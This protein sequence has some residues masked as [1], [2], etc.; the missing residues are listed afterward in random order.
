MAIVRQPSREKIKLLGELAAESTLRDEQILS[1]VPEWTRLEHAKILPPGGSDLLRSLH[2]MNLRERA[3]MIS[4]N[5]DVNHI[6]LNILNNKDDSASIQYILAIYYDV[7]RDDSSVIEGIVSSL[8]NVDTFNPFM[9]LIIKTGTDSFTCDRAGFLISSLIAR[10]PHGVYNDEQI[11]ALLD[12]VAQRKG[13]FSDAGRLDILKNILKHERHRERTW[14]TPFIKDLI[15]NN[16]DASK[17]LTIYPGVFCSWLL[18]FNPSLLAQFTNAGGIVR[19]C[20]VLRETKVEKVVRICIH[21]LLNC[22][23]SDESVEIVIQQDAVH[24]LT[25]LEYEKW[26]DQELYQEIRGGLS[27]LQQKIKLFSNFD[28]YCR[29]LATGSLSWSFLHSEKFWH[30]NILHFEENEFAAVKNLVLLLRSADPMTLAVACF[31]L[32]EF[33]RLHPTGKKMVQK[34]KAKES[35]MLLMSHKDRDV[36]REALLCTQKMF[37]GKTIE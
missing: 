9:K 15:L 17:A 23:P 18:T 27:A 4:T 13:D 14:N 10:D 3:N 5:A 34:L 1:R 32:G 35:I 28:R 31:D 19:V 12:V 8:R 11:Q 24:T 37:L 36:A 16:V 22:L 25:L 33:A 29:E 26:R 20:N 30:E 21:T 2:S 6:L 7:I